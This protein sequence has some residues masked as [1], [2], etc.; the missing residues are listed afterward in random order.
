M[1]VRNIMKNLKYFL[2][3]VTPQSMQ[4]G[5]TMACPAIYELTPKEMSCVGAI[6]C[7]GIYRTE[8]SYLIIGEKIKPEDFGLEKK[9]GENELLIKVPKKLID[10]KGK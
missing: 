2:K 5:I 1:Y 10:E 3:D 4:C 6:A 8:E 9:V 7:K